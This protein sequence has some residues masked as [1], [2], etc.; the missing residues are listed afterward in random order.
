MR[1]SARI[2]LGVISIVLAVAG[3][4]AVAVL[5]VGAV[6]T[7]A[8]PAAVAPAAATAPS[9]P[10]AEVVAAPGTP[11]PTAPPAP[12]VPAPAA[13]A[14]PSPVAGIP[15]QITTTGDGACVSISQH[16]AWLIRGG[17]ADKP[18]SVMTGRKGYPT[19]K[20][21]FTVQWKDRDHV[22]TEFDSA[23]MPYSVFFASG[24]AF[25]TGSL[26]ATSHGCV[27]LSNSAAKLFFNT[28]QEGEP[29]QVVA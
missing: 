18:V 12:V 5:G 27:H 21:R 20:G 1:K 22:S 26:A 9:T 28:L 19:P 14:P 13:P 16:K 25:H 6:R 24:V 17:V 10:A 11:T 15:C 3:V 29:V 2:G 4:A 7:A 23:P 8:S